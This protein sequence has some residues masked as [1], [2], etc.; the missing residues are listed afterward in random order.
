MTAIACRKGLILQ[1]I[2]VPAD[3]KC[4]YHAIAASL[5]MLYPQE[6]HTDTK[7]KELI[8]DWLRENETHVLEDGTTSIISFIDG[9]EDRKDWK[10]F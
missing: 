4:Q 7:V 3:G 10:D 1:A 9:P 2:D 8:I 5:N 6:N